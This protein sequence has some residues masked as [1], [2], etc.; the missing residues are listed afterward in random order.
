MSNN[1]NSAKATRQEG[2]KKLLDL[3][4]NQPINPDDKRAVWEKY[5]PVKA[6]WVI[7]ISLF[8]TA[9]LLV[10]IPAMR[11]ATKQDVTKLLYWE[12]DTGIYF[13]IV[14]LFLFNLL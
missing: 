1:L 11:L 12:V 9:Y 4:R 8:I 10:I 13:L 6:F 3:L 7:F 5:G 14:L 2:L